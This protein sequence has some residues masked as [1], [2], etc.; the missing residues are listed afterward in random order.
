M[1]FICLKPLSPSK[2]FKAKRRTLRNKTVS[3]E[4]F[5]CSHAYFKHLEHIILK[6]QPLNKKEERG[7]YFTMKKPKELH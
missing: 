5:K 1:V 7:M 3:S 4:N 6:L 2:N